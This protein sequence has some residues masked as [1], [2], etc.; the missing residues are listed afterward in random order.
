M[1]LLKETTGGAVM[2][3]ELTTD[4]SFLLTSQYIEISKLWC[5]YLR[6]KKVGVVQLVA[7]LI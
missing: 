6:R 4:R 3:P 7:C 1:F 2:G 5:N